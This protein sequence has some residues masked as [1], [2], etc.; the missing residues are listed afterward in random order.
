[1]LLNLLNFG[2]DPHNKLH[3]NAKYR[4]SCTRCANQSEFNINIL[5]NLV[6]F[7]IFNNF[8]QHFCLLSQ[9]FRLQILITPLK[10][11]ERFA[12]IC[13][14]QA[15]P[16]CSSFG[17]RRLTFPH[18]QG[19]VGDARDPLIGNTHTSV[20]TCVNTLVPLT[21]NCTSITIVNP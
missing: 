15:A 16:P 2:A 6:F 1:M 8:D 20:H 14:L 9:K 21:I 17:V 11:S 19:V 7:F 5:P 18:T 10:F 3:S 13:Y 4:R 12:L